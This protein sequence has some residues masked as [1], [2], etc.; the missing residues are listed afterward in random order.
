MVHGLE[1]FKE[2]FIDYNDQ[3]VLIGGAACDVLLGNI[4]VPFR[5][6][7]DLDIALIVERLTE[8]FGQRFWSF[9]E[10]G[11]YTNKQKHSGKNQSYRFE[12]PKQVDYPSMIELFCRKS[13]LY[14]LK[15]DTGIT[16]VYIDESVDSLSAILL[17]DAYYDLIVQGSQ[18]VDG[19]SV[20]EIESI[21]LFK[22]KAWLDMKHRVENGAKVDTSD[23]KKHRNDIFRLL[24]TVEPTKRIIVDAEIARD[25][26]LFLERINYDKPILKDLGLKG[27]KLENVLAFLKTLY[28]I[29]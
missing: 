26:I 12:K 18:L 9:I 2:Y 3:Y 13:S 5:A 22:I 6:T 8:S 21:I 16:P 15:F 7:K 10:E 4:G 29:E 11:G 23:I 1:K 28:S 20:L 17:N 25:V 14:D 19:L 27:Y 24:V